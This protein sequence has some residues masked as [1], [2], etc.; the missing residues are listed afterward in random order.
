MRILILSLTGVASAREATY[1]QNRR[2]ILILVTLTLCVPAVDATWRVSGSFEPDTPQDVLGARM[3]LDPDTSPGSPKI[4]FNAIPSD[5]NGARDFNPNVGAIGSRLLPAGN[6]GMSAFLGIWKDCNADGYIG[7]AETALLE[8]RS[9]ILTA[10]S[11]AA[12]CPPTQPTRGQITFNDGTWVTEFVAISDERSTSAAAS[13]PRIVYD[14]EVRVWGDFGR[15]DA[16]R[17]VHLDCAQV[18]L[19][20]GTFESTGGLLLYA[21]CQLGYNVART[22]NDV[23]AVAGLGLAF[24]GD[25]GIYHPERDCD[26]PLN[27]HVGLYGKSACNP[28]DP[29]LME[30]NSSRPTASVWDCDSDDATVLF[31]L[32]NPVDESDTLVTVYA[33]P[34]VVV[35]EV[36]PDGSVYTA[37]Q[38]TEGQ[39]RDEMSNN[40]FMEGTLGA[41]FSGT[42]PYDG[43]RLADFNMSFNIGAGIGGVH[44][45]VPQDAGIRG[46]SSGH[47]DSGVTYLPPTYL[48]GTVRNDDLQPAAGIWFT[49]Y[50]FVGPET[51]DRGFQVKNSA[52]GSYGVE[53]CGA[54]ED[55]VHGGWDCD[56]T[57][58]WNP[59]MGGTENPQG[60][61]PGTPYVLRDTDCYDGD[62]SDGT[63]LYASLAQLS[64][65]PA[66]PTMGA[67][68]LG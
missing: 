8:Y 22:V 15:P 46:V 47:W 53:A 44:Q 35:G 19:P 39:C 34:P 16:A 67:G 25:G 11:G 17:E 28:E 50:A 43:K 65:D 5:R 52:V 54:H 14:P 66:C 36:D 33:P 20:S 56:I 27:Q 41:D 60:P 12:A 30:G 63:G 38:H 58:W 42:N 4:Y 26:N 45:G 9:E 3:W 48:G 6:M 55:G 7:H 57:H 2:F 1:V 51:L 37:Y 24:D 31:E 68:L 62:L 21:D 18:P 40:G 23:D 13:F 61:R 10:T 32:A 59:D 64:T 49:F 29:G